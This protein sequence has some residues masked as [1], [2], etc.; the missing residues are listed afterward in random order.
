MSNTNNSCFECANCGKRAVIWQN[1]VPFSDIGML[2][3]GIVREYYCKNCG[4]EISYEIEEEEPGGQHD[5]NS[6]TEEK[7][8]GGE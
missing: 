7:D 2:G 3:D 8:P 1:D 5:G 4:A 6:R